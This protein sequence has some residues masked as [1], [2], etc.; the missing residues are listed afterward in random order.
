MYNLAYPVYNDFN[1]IF[2][3]PNVIID[4]STPEATIGI[5]DFAISKAEGN[6][7]KSNEDGLY[8]ENSSAAVY[9]SELSDNIK[10]NTSVGGL[11]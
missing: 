8:V 5:L 10:M 9:K 7:I 2:E 4:F 1:N 6:A 11:K 3:L